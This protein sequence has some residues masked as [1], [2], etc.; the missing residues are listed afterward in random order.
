[1]IAKAELQHLSA[2]LGLMEQFYQEEGLTFD[3]GRAQRALGLLLAD[4]QHG[5][6]LLAR[7][8]D[9]LAACAA[10][11]ACFSLEFGG[12]FALLDELFVLPACRGEGVGR[13]LLQAVFEECRAR[14]FG[15]I[16]LEVEH[17][18]ERAYAVYRK[19]GFEPHSRHLMTR[20]L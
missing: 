7:H 8:S 11:T 9:D 6:V 1:M 2:L 14:R 5:F 4:A 19:L 12:P 15:A 20:W 3:S 18:N 13:M 16:R 17:E 10:V